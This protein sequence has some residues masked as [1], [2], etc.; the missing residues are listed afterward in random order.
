MNKHVNEYF[1]QYSESSNQGNFHK[2]IA[3][4]DA[5]DINWN[6]ISLIAP[7]LSKGWFELCQL[8]TQD[9]LDFT[10]EF[11]LSK[12]PYYPKISQTLL[13]FFGALDD[14]GVFLSQ[15]KYDDPFHVQMVY[16]LSE[17]RGFYR[18]MPNAREEDLLNLQK[19]FPEI[20]L[21]KDYLAFL[22]IHNGFCKATDCTGI[23]NTSTMNKL[24]TEFQT[25]LER[26][27]EVTTKGGTPV[28]PRTLIPFYESFGMP[29]YQC[30]WNEWHPIQEMG[31]VYYSGADNTI[32]NPLKKMTGSIEHMAFPTFSDWLAFYLEQIDV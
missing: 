32:S 5:P 18:G 30:F 28:N 24:Y 1:C 13:K 20:I 23:T 29:Y 16:S 7:N 15:K 31:N 14:I 8:P 2:V 6:T 3:I 17:D 11:W 25:Y 10:F 12:L 9:R 21:P 19:L 4:Q 26:Q 27:G 22:Q